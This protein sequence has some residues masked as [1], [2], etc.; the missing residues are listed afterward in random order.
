MNA[1]L[2]L[3]VA[4]SRS[5]LWLFQESQFHLLFPDPP[6]QLL[7]LGALRQFQRRLLAGVGVPISLHPISESGLAE[8]VFAGDLGDRP[9]CLDD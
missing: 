4:P 1:Y 3:T 5:T 2:S 8:P 7:Q 9:L 6:A